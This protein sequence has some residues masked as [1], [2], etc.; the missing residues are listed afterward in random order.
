MPRSF[1]LQHHGGSPAPTFVSAP[2]DREPAVRVAMKTLLEQ[3]RASARGPIEAIAGGASGSDIVFHEV[4]AE[5]GIPTRLLLALP[6]DRYLAHSVQDSGP[7]WVERFWALCHSHEPQVLSDSN[8][9][10][11]WLAGI[12][13]YTIWQRNNLWTMATGLSAERAEVTLLTVW[14]GK[15]GDGPG[16]TADMVRLA[17]E[18]GVKV[19]DSIDPMKV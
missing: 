2:A 14:D 4:C 6:A 9:L 7:K 16:G 17:G 15:P 10:P 19:L 3:E 18:R 11:D 8:E 13:G 1:A 5:L 12:T